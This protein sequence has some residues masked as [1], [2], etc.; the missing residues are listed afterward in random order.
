MGDSLRIALWAGAGTAVALASVALGY[1]VSQNL[2]S[3]NIVLATGALAGAVIFLGVQL[4]FGVATVAG[5]GALAAAIIVL[6]IQL[7]FELHAEKSTDFITA[8][9]TIDRAKPEIRQWKYDNGQRL[10]RDLDGSRAFAAVHP[11][12]FD[13]DREKLTQDMVIFS[14]L[15]YLGVEQFDWQ[16]KRTQFVGQSTGTITL[17]APGS[18]PDECTLVTKD[19]LR[20]M[21]LNVGNSFA[22]GNMFFGQQF[23]SLPPRSTLQVTAAGVTLTNPFCELSF[24][25]EPS[26]G[27][28]YGR[29]ATD[30]KPLTTAAAVDDWI[31][32]SQPS[33][34][35]GEPVFESRTTGIR[36]TV[37]Y[38]AIRAQHRDMSKYQDW[39]KRL[40]SGAQNWFMGELLI[41]P[42]LKAVQKL[43]NDNDKSRGEMEELRREIATLIAT[44]REPTK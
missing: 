16:M 37:R 8:E 27:V 14:L 38:S 6:C 22:D 43:N 41:E 23:L 36:V 34:P 40:V 15:A 24:A 12:Q 33:L 5:A 20:T 29:L 9:Y 10:I 4:L 3:R 25:L 28:R 19:Q 32:R 18:K 39:S 1:V 7:F 21:L 13:G 44:L 17:T 42:L 2:R 26:G 31:K 30:E 11:G 35:N